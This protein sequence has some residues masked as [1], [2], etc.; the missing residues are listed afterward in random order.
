[1]SDGGIEFVFDTILTKLLLS[2]SRTLRN[3]TVHGLRTKL[4]RLTAVYLFL[5]P[6]I[7]KKEEKEQ[8]LATKRLRWRAAVWKLLN[9]VI[10][11]Q[12]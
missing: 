12:E 3:G 10:G 7:N 8:E 2:R 9:A 6:V 5:D 11:T 1:M 4:V